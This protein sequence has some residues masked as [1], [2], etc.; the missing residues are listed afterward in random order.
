MLVAVAVLALPFVPGQSVS[1]RNV[2]AETPGNSIA[3]MELAE[4]QYRHALRMNPLCEETYAKLLE[5]AGDRP[6]PK[7]SLAYRAARELLSRR[8]LEYETRRFIVLSDAEPRWSRSQAEHLERS[9]HQFMRFTNRLGLR[10]LPLQHKL[11]CVLFE[12]ESDYRA[13]AAEQDG[14]HDPWIVGYYSPRHD[15]VVFFRTADESGREVPENISIA[16]TVHE[17][18]HQLHFHTRVKS[19]N[20]QYPLWIC[21]GIATAF[22]TD[23]PGHAF[24]PDHEFI[25]RRTRFSTLLAADELLPLRELVVLTVMNGASSEQVSAM[26]HQ[27]YALVVWLNRF[28]RDGLRD[29]LNAM[30]IE[31]PGHVT[32]KRQLE[33]FEQAFGDVDALERRWLDH[34]QR[35]LAALGQE[36]HEAA[37][38][39]LTAWTPSCL[40]ARGTGTFDNHE[41]RQRLVIGNLNNR[42][43]AH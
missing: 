28:R 10:P 9:H 30:L 2:Q 35:N 15:R 43:C 37:R 17:A 11:V 24:G 36:D 33:I 41:G 34:E 18:I 26:Y 12:R 39:A 5:V 21:E 40:C 8:F 31:P 27:S 25:P 14:I 19:V 3:A 38:R 7:D 42:S 32:E 1:P 20:V 29:Y 4:R 6:I 13:F 23:E 22:E 16:T